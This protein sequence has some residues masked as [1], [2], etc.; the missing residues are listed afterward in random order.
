MDYKALMVK[1]RKT[2]DYRDKVD[3]QYHSDCPTDGNFFQAIRTAMFAIEAGITTDN[4]DF[5]AEAQAILEVAITRMN[6]DK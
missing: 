6:G 2:N 1:A 4:W 3:R 5:I